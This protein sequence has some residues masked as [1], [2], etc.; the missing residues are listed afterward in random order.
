[1]AN[2]ILRLRATGGFEAMEVADDIVEYEELHN[3]VG[4]CIEHANFSK[5]LDQIGVDMWVDEE[6]KLKE[7]NPSCAIVDVTVYGP[8]IIDIINGNIVFTSKFS[9]GIFKKKE[10]DGEAHSLSHSQISQIKLIF[11]E[12][13]VL[14]SNENS[15]KKELRILKTL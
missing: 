2:K 3:A 8:R 15:L 7:L 1:M 10:I 5:M 4:G 14:S 9:N 11:G 13:F 6:G 12:Y